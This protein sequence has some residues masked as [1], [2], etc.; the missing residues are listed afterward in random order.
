MKDGRV[1]ASSAA[2]TMREDARRINQQ[3]KRIIELTTE[4]MDWGETVI[5]LNRRID[6]L[7]GS[8]KQYERQSRAAGA[9]IRQLERNTDE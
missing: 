4:C 6:Q 3:R 7:E 2:K 8:C 1:W 5:H 9:R